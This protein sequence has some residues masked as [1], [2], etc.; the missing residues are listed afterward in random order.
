[1]GVA[2]VVILAIVWL[3]LLFVVDLNWLGLRPVNGL[4]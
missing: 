4:N 2:V 1:V 3:M